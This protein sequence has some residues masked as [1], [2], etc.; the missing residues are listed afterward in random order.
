MAES[1]NIKDDSMQ[2]QII[3]A[4][5]QLFQRHGLHKVTMD[6]VAKEIG[7]RRSSLYYYYKNKEEI[8]DAA[9]DVELREMIAEISK[10][11]NQAIG[12]EAQLHAYFSARL[13]ISQKRRTMS[14]MLDAP[15]NADEISAYEQVKRTIHLRFSKLEIPLLQSILEKGTAEKAIRQID[16]KEMETVISLIRSCLRGFK[17]DFIMGKN[18]NQLKPEVT[19]LVEMILSFFE[20]G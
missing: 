13:K 11:A 2:Q 6:E 17:R 9:I 3:Q 8:L 20:K 10:A 14:S 5:Q 15:M 19:M 16:T 7:K 4:A 18:F 1:T 12:L